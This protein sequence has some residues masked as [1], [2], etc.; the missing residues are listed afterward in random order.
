MNAMTETTPFTKAPR[1]KHIAAERQLLELR[2]TD[3]QR[4]RYFAGFLPEDELLMLAR[5]L[6]YAPFA[7]LR[8]W[9]KIHQ[10]A[11][12]H[13]V[14]CEVKFTSDAGVSFATRAAQNMSADEW[15]MF[16][17]ILDIANTVTHR[18]LDSAS[19]SVEVIEHIGECRGCHATVS[20]KSASVRITWAG[21]ELSREYSLE[22][23]R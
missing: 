12:R 4:E 23:P 1:T 20:G 8:R 5:D 22:M 7:G 6:L 15:A 16:K 10:G 21:R 18:R 11:V 9:A 2:G 13:R 3:E 17:T 14:G 19:I